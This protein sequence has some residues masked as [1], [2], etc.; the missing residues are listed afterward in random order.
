MRSRLSSRL[1][2]LAALLPLLAFAVAGVGYDRLRC[3]FTGEISEIGCCAHDDDAPTQPTAAAPSCCDR[4][5]ARVVRLPAEPAPSAPV[6]LAP[7][8]SSVAF[9]A[10]A[11][12]SAAEFARRTDAAPPPRRPLPL[13]KQ[14]FLI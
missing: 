14:S 12:D 1:V 3:A 11:P 4:E 7:T 9:S 8:T 6:A 2:G 13:L 5:V 10:P